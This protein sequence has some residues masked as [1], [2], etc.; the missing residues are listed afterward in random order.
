MQPSSNKQSI[1]YWLALHHING[2]GYRSVKHLLTQVNLA[3]LFSLSANELAKLKLHSK[4][5]TAITNPPWQQVDDDLNWLMQSHDHAILSIASPE[6]PNLLLETNQPPL[7]L[8]C[9]GDVSYLQQPQLAIV[10]SRNPSLHGKQNAFTFAK[11]L[12]KAGL[13]ITSGLALGVDTAAHLG[14]LAANK[15]TIAVLGSGLNNI[16]PKQNHELAAK[17]RENGVII[18]EFSASVA[19]QANHFPRR[20]R[21]I[22]GLSLGVF[23][24]EAALKSGSLIT[25]HYA[26][27]QN[28]DVF[29][30][31]GSIH[32][33]LA[34]GCHYLLKQGAKLVESSQDLAEELQLSTPTP[35][36]IALP[37]L[38]KD[39]TSTQEKLYKLMGYDE[40]DAEQLSAHCGFDA[41]T[42]STTLQSLSLRGLISETKNGYIRNT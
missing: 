28:R 41:A 19:P 16:Y 34:K 15:P 27:D 18:S 42:I 40:I 30:M 31:P 21:I 2:L 32:N 10:G 14:C 6:Y 20:N 7:V 33:P 8:Y 29:A 24:V 25:A 1:R 37:E 39:L 38:P 36:E 11:S 3:E 26:L 9:Q 17:I 4:I 23:V 22:S 12:A 5:I 13:N 35:R